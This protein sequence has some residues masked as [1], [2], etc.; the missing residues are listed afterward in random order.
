MGL[1]NTADIYE[2]LLHGSVLIF[3]VVHFYLIEYKY[4][5]L[6]LI[7]GIF[8]F[9]S[10]CFYKYFDQNIN[11]KNFSFYSGFLIFLP[12]SIFEDLLLAFAIGISTLYTI[13]VYIL[14]YM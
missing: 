7:G 10:L 2:Y 9:S 1:K 5:F 11:V 6:I 12:I 4:Y 8:L 14:A 13:F 3:F